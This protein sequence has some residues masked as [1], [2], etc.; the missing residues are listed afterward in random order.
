MSVD[1]PPTLNQVNA[2]QA[3]PVQF[4][5]GG[6]Q[7]LTIL[8]SGYPTVQQVSC[9]TSAPVNTATLTDTAGGSGLSYNST[10]NIYTYVW[11]TSK[12]WSGTCQ[13]FD[14]KLA[15]G[16]RHLADFQFN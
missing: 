9:S 4:S 15:D 6:N 3:I 13:Q 16:T 2:G 8:A 11:K 5:L 1:N 14:M 7:G 10:T 12:T